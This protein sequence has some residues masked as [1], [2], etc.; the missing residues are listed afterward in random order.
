MKFI[1]RT[2]ELDRLAKFYNSDGQRAALVYGRRRVGKSEL[3]TKSIADLKQTCI[4]YECKQTSEM[5]N[6]GSLAR[7]IA[8]ILG[9]PPFAF[10]SMEEALSY[11]FDRSTSEDIVLVLDE[12]PYL[13]KATTG[14]DSV[15]QT[16]LDTH[17]DKS[18]LKLV[19]CG[20]YIDVMRSLMQEQNPLFGRIDLAID[21]K[22]MDYW[23]SA[24]FYPS[25]SHEDKVRLYSVFGGIPHYNRLIDPD[26]TVRDN[27]IELVTSPGARL[28][29]EIALYL[30]SELSKTANANE[31]FETLADGYSRYSDIR[32]Q[33]H[34]SSDPTLVDA[35][36]RL[37]GLELVAKEAPINDPA[38]KRKARYLISDNLALFY[39]RYVFPNASSRNVMDP[40]RFYE[41]FIERDFEEQ[42]VPRR[43]ERI[44]QQFL[45]RENIAS[46]LRDPFEQ[47]GRYWYDIPSEH[48]NGEFDIVT[49][50]GDDYVFYEAKFRS[51]PISRSMVE[52]E[53]EQVKATGLSCKAYGF[54]SRSGFENFELDNVRK[55]DL[56]DLFA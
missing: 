19:L 11:L 53:I 41:R 33:S 5:N 12:Y 39:Y 8:E 37:E 48:R 16:L 52:E 13:R 29:N 1:G 27:I 55:Y 56:D 32:D 35:L 51:A 14:M 47:I 20:S 31:V 45:V 7:I 18:H 43:F 44:C 36:K 54:I 34:I 28:D 15:I 30:K 50:D 40:Q 38:N 17:R 46:R 3:I 49:R 25:F 22:P 2:T 21:L 4:Y 6:V 26:A 23:D 9:Q 10:Q 24:Q 42:H